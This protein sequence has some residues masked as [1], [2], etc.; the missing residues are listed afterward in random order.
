MFGKMPNKERMENYVRARR[1]VGVAVFIWGSHMLLHWCF[2]FRETNPEM[3]SSIN[4]ISYYCGSNLFGWSLIS[5]LNHKYL[6][7][8]RVK[9]DIIKITAYSAFILCNLIFF[10]GQIASI[11]LHIAAAYFVIDITMLCRRFFVSYSKAKKQVESYYSE[12][13]N[14]FIQWLN[15]CTYCII[16]AGLIGAAMAFAPIW[17][18]TIY[19]LF[20]VLIF[21]Y[22][23]I[24]FQNYLMY[25]EY[26]DAAIKV[27]DDPEIDL[28]NC[29]KEK[30]AIIK[31]QIDIWI[32]QKGY[33]INEINI[34]DLAR[35]FG[36]NR[37]YLSTY[38]NEMYKCN[39]RQF[40]LSMRIEEAKKILSENT[41]NI[42]EV[43]EAVGFS[44]PSHFSRSFKNIVGCSPND[45][46]TSNKNY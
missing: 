36:T 21:L 17:C 43:S 40:I 6:S 3:A 32:D 7:K 12:D 30:Y 20:G 27:K 29:K 38:I 14:S 35:K 18:N 46:N 28:H 26:V 4:F 37:T 16:I 41:K 5:L 11:L 31:E 10:S 33:L 44:T 1:I 45:Y 39:F 9:T 22:V 25:Y 2:K 8:K 24:S 23:F 19:T 34:E 42:S 13:I 15:N